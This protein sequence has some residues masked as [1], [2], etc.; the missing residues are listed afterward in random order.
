MTS[1]HVRL[2]NNIQTNSKLLS[3]ENDKLDNLQ[4]E[5]VKMRKFNEQEQ[6]GHDLI[7]GVCIVIL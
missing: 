1:L 4:S 5:L 7:S 6:Y 3:I 2:E